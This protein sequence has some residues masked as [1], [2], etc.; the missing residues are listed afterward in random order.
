MDYKD[1]ISLLINISN[2]KT[3]LFNDGIITESEYYN[4]IDII[5]E[6]KEEVRILYE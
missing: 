1:I 6:I 3:A 4:F 2:N 5:D